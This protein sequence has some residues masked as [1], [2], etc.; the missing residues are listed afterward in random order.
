M[1]SLDI[2]FL[3]DRHLDTTTKATVVPESQTS[4]L[5][6]QLP[7]LIG[8][9]VMVILPAITASSLLVLN[10][11]SSSTEQKIQELDLQLEQVSAQNRSIDEIN[12]KVE[13]NNR[14][15]ESLVTV[16]NQIRPWSA[17][18]SELE[19]Q[20]PANVRVDSIVQTDS[21]LTIGGYAV[22]YDDINDFLLT[23]QSS[24][25]L[26]AEKTIIETASLEDFPVET[27]NAPENIEVEVPQGIKY[28]IT[29]AISDRPSSE[30]LQDFARNGATG[31]VNRIRTLENKGVLK[32]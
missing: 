1:Y 11:L 7:L 3:K 2:N 28:S 14:E 22:D 29:T 23:L 30:L 10:Q 17:I 5:T 18:L 4:S 13:Q 15:V 8:G 21:E 6:E 31:L 24:P 26:D 19:D 20:T 12:A 9:A 25:L 16:F 32:P 27:R